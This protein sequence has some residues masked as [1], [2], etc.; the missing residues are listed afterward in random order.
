MSINLNKYIVNLQPLVIP[1]S[2]VE[3]VE[4]GIHSIGR[5]GEFAIKVKN[6]KYVLAEKASVAFPELKGVTP[7]GWSKGRTWDDSRAVNY[8]GVI[9]FFSIDKK[10]MSPYVLHETGH[11]L[12]F[13]FNNI[14]GSNFTK[15]NGYEDCYVKDLANLKSTSAMLG[16]EE[17][18]LSY[19]IQGSTSEKASEAGKQEAFA[20]IYAH[21]RGGSTSPV[22]SMLNELFPN[23]LAYVKKLLWYLGDKS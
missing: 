21:L 8:N 1:Q 19:M 7:R 4:K 16:I 10:R 5:S 13:S 23:T 3:S 18:N 14:I 20:N 9:G 2:F 12:D 17:K 22:D 6:T 11:E 15:T